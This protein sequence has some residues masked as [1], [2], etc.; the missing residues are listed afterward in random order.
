MPIEPLTHVTPDGDHTPNE[1]TDAA[2]WTGY[3]TGVATTRNALPADGE[4]RATL[5]STNSVR[6]GQNLVGR[7]RKEADLIYVDVS[8]GGAGAFARDRRIDALVGLAS[9]T[10]AK[11]KLLRAAA[12]ND[13]AIMFDLSPVI[14]G[15]GRFRAMKRLIANA[16]RC[17][18]TGCRTLL[19]AGAT[20]PYDLR[21]PR[22][23]KALAELSGFTPEQAE[24]ALA[25]PETLL[26]AQHG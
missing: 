11:T 12:R 9:E 18:D 6:E 1:L 7:Y 2:R 20:H 15:T 23:I 21:A 14:T 19:T 16:E 5:I 24:T 8:R 17:R 4:Y 25:L 3:R 26:E 22:E 13:V 10:F